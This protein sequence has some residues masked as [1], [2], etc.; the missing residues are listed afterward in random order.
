MMKYLFKGPYSMEQD[1]RLCYAMRNKIYFTLKYQV[2]H[3]NHVLGH[4]WGSLQGT[5]L[6]V[7]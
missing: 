4:F 1:L 7:I 3:V 6:S 5:R 2:L